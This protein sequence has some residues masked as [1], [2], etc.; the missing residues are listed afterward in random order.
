MN[1]ESSARIAR[2]SSTSSTTRI[3]LFSVP[4]MPSHR[5]RTYPVPADAPKQRPVKNALPFPALIHSFMLHLNTAIQYVL[6][7]TFAKAFRNRAETAQAAPRM[8]KTYIEHALWISDPGMAFP[9]QRTKGA[10]GSGHF[11]S[12]FEELHW[13]IRRY[14]PVSLISILFPSGSSRSPTR[15]SSLTVSSFFDSST[16]I[17]TPRPCPQSYLRNGHHHPLYTMNRHPFHL[18]TG[19]QKRGYILTFSMIQ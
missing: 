5:R 15:V 10:I 18:P 13:G 11:S 8:G 12:L 17:S 4:I 9:D 14:R 16:Q 1:P 7:I 6:S 3:C 19:H 2:F